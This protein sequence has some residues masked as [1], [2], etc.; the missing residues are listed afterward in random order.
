MR[1]SLTIVVFFFNLSLPAQDI[2]GVWV[3]NYERTLLMQQPEKL[4]VEIYLY[5][6]SL[7]TGVSHLYYH[8]NEYE[9]YKIYGV[10]NRAKSTIY[11]SEDSTIE[12]K[13]GFMDTNC[14]GNY[15]MNL[16]RTDS[17]LTLKG[18]WS[19]NNP[20]LFGCPTTGVWLRKDLTPDQKQSTFKT[21][22]KNLKRSSDIQS[23]IEISD[24]E[25]DSIEISIF[26]NGVIDNDS[27]SL[28]LNDS[29]LIHKKMI[30][31]KPVSLFISLDKKIP[32][33]KIKLSAENLGSIPPCTAFMTIKTRKKRYEVSLSSSFS[34]NAVVEFFLKE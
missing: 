33:N 7:I 17:S 32:L 11:F 19:D 6:D 31:N 3:G 14:M 34:S 16:K 1:L 13:L 26:D 8:D 30:S 2:S 29:L 25:T 23:L 18:R 24:K 4:V 20:R 21:Q 28:Y 15:Y 27:I 10:Y 9:H 5:N 12:V 22:D